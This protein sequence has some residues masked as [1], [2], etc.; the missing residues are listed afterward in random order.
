MVSWITLSPRTVS[1][2]TAE[3]ARVGVGPPHHHSSSSFGVEARERT[4]A[5]A[6]ESLLESTY[7]TVGGLDSVLSAAM[8]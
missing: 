2:M 5:F 3:L 8:Q 6:A 4:I 7:W 1:D